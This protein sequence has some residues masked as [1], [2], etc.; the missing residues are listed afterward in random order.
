MY[1]LVAGVIVN[2]A[3][4]SLEVGHYLDS[5]GAVIDNS[6]SFI[7]NKISSGIPVRGMSQGPL[8]LADSG[9][10]GWFPF[11]EQSCCRHHK[12]E[13][14]LLIAILGFQVNDPL[15]FTIVP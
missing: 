8:V 14:L 2:V 9:V 12:V 6:D 4:R 15:R 3:D 11:V 13:S 1:R 7:F 5:A 10:V